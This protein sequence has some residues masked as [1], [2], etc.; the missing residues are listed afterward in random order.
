MKKGSKPNSMSVAKLG[1]G[2]ASRSL[3]RAPP[4]GVHGHCGQEEFMMTK[5]L[6]LSLWSSLEAIKGTH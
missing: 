5:H 4:A 1:D 6:L 2:Q 3:L